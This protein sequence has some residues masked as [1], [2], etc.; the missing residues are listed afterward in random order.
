MDINMCRGGREA[1]NVGGVAYVSDMLAMGAPQEMLT[2]QHEPIIKVYK[3]TYQKSKQEAISVS[4]INSWQYRKHEACGLQQIKGKGK[5]TTSGQ[6]AFLKKLLN[7]QIC[8]P[9]GFSWVV[10]AKITTVNKTQSLAERRNIAL[11]PQ[12]LAFIPSSNPWLKS[13][14]T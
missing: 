3:N 11:W 6:G 5:L 12:Y 1:V 7:Q 14:T 2:K 8:C 10:A 9:L 13:R 4:S